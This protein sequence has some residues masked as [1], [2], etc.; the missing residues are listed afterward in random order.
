MTHRVVS[1]ISCCRSKIMGNLSTCTGRAFR[2]PQRRRV[3]WF[4]NFKRISR[5]RWSNFLYRVQ[6]EKQEIHH[7]DECYRGQHP[8]IAFRM[9]ENEDRKRRR[10]KASFCRHRR[11]E[12][13]A[14]LRVFSGTVSGE[15]QRPPDACSQVQGRQVLHIRKQRTRSR[16]RYNHHD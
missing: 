8:G 7:Q 10:R 2:I 4:N 12:G 5:C 6:V 16:E 14:L 13:R 1:R 3:A 15:R 9:P 11:M